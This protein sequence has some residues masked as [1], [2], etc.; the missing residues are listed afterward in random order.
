MARGV[1]DQVGRRSP[2]FWTL[3]F[4][5]LGIVFLY[6]QRTRLTRC[7]DALSGADWRWLLALGLIEA[8]AVGLTGLTYRSS[9]TQLG[10]LLSWRR[11]VDLHLERHVVGTITPVG[12]PA[13]MYAFIRRIQT[14]GVG[15]SDA[16]LALG[17]RSVAGYSAFVTLLLPALIIH[18]PSP[19]VLGA[20]AALSAL[21]LVLLVGFFMLQRGKGLPVAVTRRLPSGV[22]RFLA[23]LT[24]HRLTPR[25][26]FWPFV[27][28][29]ATNLASAFVLLV[30]LFA[31][32]ASPSLTT[33]IAGYAIGNLFLLV[34]PI[35]QGIGVVELTM[36]V[37]LQQLGIP[38]PTAVGATLLFRFG[39][40]WMPLIAGAI[41]QLERRIR[42]RS[43][44]AVPSLAESQ[45]V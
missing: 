36:A 22:M 8:A 27:F 42:I 35:F 6:F 37:A 44:P 20:F 17:V 43:I 34:A 41:I 12:G 26:F 7:A 18:H 11:C 39:D 19:M 5:A 10:H 13:S 25:A 24:N 31:M 30:A 33:A 16:L 38:L 29:F 14:D 40:V 3:F 21:L 32:G 28:A 45:P 2:R 4:V 23:Q 15:S 9:L 1:Y